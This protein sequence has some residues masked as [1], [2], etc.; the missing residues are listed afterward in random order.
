MRFKNCHVTGRPFVH[1]N[2]ELLSI[3]DTD[4]TKYVA[5]M[6]K[7]VTKTRTHVNNIYIRTYIILSIGKK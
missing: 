2:N 1:L 5:H 4:G 3:D 6:N 7:L